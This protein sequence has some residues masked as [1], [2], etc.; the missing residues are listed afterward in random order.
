M[1]NAAVEQA[2]LEQLRVITLGRRPFADDA[3][4]LRFYPHWERDGGPRTSGKHAPDDPNDPACILVEL[5]STLTGCRW[6]LARW[7]ELEERLT[8]GMAL[9]SADKLK[10][11]RLLGKQPLDAPDEPVVCFILLP[12]HVLYPRYSGPFYELECEFSEFESE[13]HRFL[14]RIKD[15][16]CKAVRPKSEAEARQAILS[17]VDKATVR[18]PHLARV[19]PGDEL[20]KQP[21]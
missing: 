20:E 19:V 7:A 6:L 17:L 9:Q 10:A 11:I 16:P 3:E 12:A 13:W 14:S 4:D 8:P 15:R 1:Q 2:K 21:R 5:E 18:R